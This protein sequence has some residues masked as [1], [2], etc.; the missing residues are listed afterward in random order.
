MYYTSI[1]ID[2]N[3]SGFVNI[4]LIN[5]SYNNFMQAKQITPTQWILRIVRGENIIA[6]LTEFCT[7]HKIEGGFFYGIGAVE[8]TEL[9]HYDV[10]QKQYSSKKFD[11]P[12][13]LVSLIGSIGKEEKLI[14]HAHAT[15]SDPQMQTLGGHLVEAKV[16]GTAEIYLTTTPL[17]PKQHDSETGLKLFALE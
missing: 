13:E 2:S 7:Q 14:V 11:Q 4:F 3:I 10:T 17:L 15:L 16:S 1:L 9:A 6:S 12:L 5:S 8:G